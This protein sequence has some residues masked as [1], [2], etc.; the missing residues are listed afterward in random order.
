[1]HHAGLPLN[2]LHSAVLGPTIFCAVVSHG[3]VLPPAFGC[4][5]NGSNALLD[6]CGLHGV[7]SLLG[8][9]LILCRRTSVVSMSFNAYLEVGIVFQQNS[10]LI[11]CSQA[12]GLYRRLVGVEVNAKR[13]ES[14]L[15]KG[16]QSLAVISC[17][18]A[19]FSTM[20][21]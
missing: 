4:H 1:M 8:E 21:S 5:A 16:L 19:F 13:N 2:Y 12:L 9:G 6:N 18:N 3:L 10:Y 17:S 15:V 7:G 11:Y 14:I 20:V